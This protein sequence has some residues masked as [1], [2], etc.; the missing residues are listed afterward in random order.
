MAA[1]TPIRKMFSVWRSWH[2]A[3]QQRR[4]MD[5]EREIRGYLLEERYTEEYIVSTQ[6]IRVLGP[7]NHLGTARQ[8]TSFVLYFICFRSRLQ[9]VEREGSHFAHILVLT[10]KTRRSAPAAKQTCWE[11]ICK[12]AEKLR[13]IW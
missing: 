11:I 9:T 6:D 12:I 10:Y 4:R 13:V 1:E 3:C 8:V 5:N 2:H 7:S